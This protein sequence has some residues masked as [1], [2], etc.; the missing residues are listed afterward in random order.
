M[1]KG[2]LRPVAGQLY[3]FILTNERAGYGTSLYILLLLLVFAVFG[4]HVSGITTIKCFYF[5]NIGSIK[6]L[7]EVKIIKIKLSLPSPSRRI[8]GLVYSSDHFRHLY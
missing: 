7:A 8:G 4:L 6:L 3:L 1:P 2:L 5:S